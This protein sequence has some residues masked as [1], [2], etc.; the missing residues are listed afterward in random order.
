MQWTEMVTART[1]VVVAFLTVMPALALPC[2][3]RWL[4]R[5]RYGPCTDDQILREAGEPDRGD[6][7]PSSD[8]ARGGADDAGPSGVRPSFVPDAALGGRFH[9]I[10]QRLQSLG[11]HYMRLERLERPTPRYRFQCLIAVQGSAAY[12]RPFQVTDRDPLEAMEEV[13]GQVESWCAVRG[14]P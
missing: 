12:S 14:G 4:D 8:A 10:Q 13:L 3:G 9:F 11:V 7:G 6:G 5:V 1:V 2:V